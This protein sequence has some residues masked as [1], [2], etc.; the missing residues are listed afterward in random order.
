M[1][2][3]PSPDQGRTGLDSRWLNLVDTDTQEVL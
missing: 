3:Q 1:N 2:R